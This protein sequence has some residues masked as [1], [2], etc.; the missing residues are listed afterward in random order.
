MEESLREGIF[1]SVV[2]L[3]FISGPI[4]NYFKKGYILKPFF[5]RLSDQKESFYE[6]HRKCIDFISL[7]VLVLLGIGMVFL[8]IPSARDYSLARDGECPEI[9]GKILFISSEDGE[10]EMDR[11]LTIEDSE[12]GQIVKVRLKC[13]LLNENEIVRVRYGPNTGIGELIESVD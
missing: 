12:T 4:Q 9:E 2:V 13:E 3:C 5:S 11:A 10:E 1:V 8:L 6:Q 7:I